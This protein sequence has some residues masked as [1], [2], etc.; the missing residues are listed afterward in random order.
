ML[1]GRRAREEDGGDKREKREEGRG[2]RMRRSWTV[3]AGREVD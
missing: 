2:K 1:L 3:S